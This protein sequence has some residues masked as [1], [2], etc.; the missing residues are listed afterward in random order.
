MNKPNRASFVETRWDNIKEDVRR[1]NP[2]F[3]EVVDDLKTKNDYPLYIVYYPF[4]SLIIDTG[5]FR[6]PLKDGSLAP[7]TCSAISSDIREQLGY[8]AGSIPLGLV[9]DHSV[10]LFLQTEDRVIPSA[11]TKSGKLI[12]LWAALSS[13]HV[14]LDAWHMTA[15]ARSIFVLPKIT[16]TAGHKKL[17]RARNIKMPLPRNLGMHWSLLTKVA[18]HS[19]FSQPWYTKVLLF[20]KN[21]LSEQKNDSWIRFQR[22]LYQEAWIGTEYWRRKIV[23]DHI[24]DTIIRELTKND[25]RATP[26]IIDIV[27]YIIMVGLGAVPGFCPAVNNE[28]VPVEGLQE[29][30]IKLY[31]LKNYAPTIM[32]PHHFSIINKRPVYWSL[33]MP[34]HL[35]STVKPKT[36]TSTLVILREIRDLM[37]YF[38]QT[39]LK[40]SNTIKDSPI[41]QFLTQVQFD[42]FHSEP[43]SE[44]QI[45]LSLE[46]PKGDSSL[47]HCSSKFGQRLFSDVSPFVR[48]CVRFSTV[49]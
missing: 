22:F 4:G 29:D 30:F 38:K 15:G 14:W 11:V 28:E 7:I 2:E 20:S 42:F 9:L 23:Y 3:A 43:D 27:K 8:N 37:L 16:D 24:W 26:F 48:G 49:K 32:V 47:I 33:T 10:E 12:G 13:I 17:C 6:F 21:W 5:R 44:G 39:I 1:V 18:Q 25:I 35:E 36:L 31:G 19:D 46:M 40:N 41:E 34:T 45:R